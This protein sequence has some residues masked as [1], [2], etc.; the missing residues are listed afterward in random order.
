[1][2]LSQGFD[3]PAIG[4]KVHKLNPNNQ[5]WTY[6]ALRNMEMLV[7]AKILSRPEPPKP[8]GLNCGACVMSNEHVHDESEW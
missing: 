3:T 4:G 6:E 7:V 8:T 5:L 1:L 2:E